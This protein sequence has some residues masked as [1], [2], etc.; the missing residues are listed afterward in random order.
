[1]IDNRR[2]YSVLSARYQRRTDLDDKKTTDSRGLTCLALLVA[3]ARV[4]HFS[5]V[6]HA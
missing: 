1:M 3:A 5:E 6:S 4:R 2:Q